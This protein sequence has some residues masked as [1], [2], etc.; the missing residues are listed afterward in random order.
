MRMLRRRLHDHRQGPLRLRD[1]RSKGTC[2]NASHQSLASP[3]PEWTQGTPHEAGNIICSL[4]D[5]V[6]L[7]PA[8]DTLAIKLDGDLA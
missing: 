6:E 7:M 1:A 3:D 8:G 5:R 2:S 4:I